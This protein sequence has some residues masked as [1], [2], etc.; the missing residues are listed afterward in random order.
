MKL[1]DI[2]RAYMLAE[3]LYGVE[4]D[5]FE[6]IALNAWELINNKHTR[7]Y[8]IVLD[9]NSDCEIELPCNVDVIRSVHVPIVDAEVLT[10]KDIPINFENP[11]IEHYIELWKPFV[12]PTYQ[13]G[14]LVKYREED[15]VLKFA[16]PYKHV[17]IVYE[18]YIVDEETG[19]PKITEQ[20]AQAIAM[21]IAYASLYK[22][23][24][25]KKD[26]GLINIAQDLYQKWLRACNA[27][28]VPE[29][30]NDNDIDKILD[31]K[32]SWNRKRYHISFVTET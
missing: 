24:I 12:D 10:N 31:A 11:V 22:D 7:L 2:H 3:Q 17:M 14:K 8:R 16:K 29:R 15:N 28:R 26:S 30:I 23:G 4:A 32:V 6:E 18:G 21:Y 13:S 1:I 27:A 9:A 5:N 19:L 20:E 25:R